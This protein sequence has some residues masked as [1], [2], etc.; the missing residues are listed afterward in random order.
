[1][2]IQ[3]YL[4]FNGNAE[5]A[6]AFYEKALGAPRSML[7]RFSETPDPVPEGMIPA[8]WGDKV[9]HASIRVGEIDLM[10]SDG[11]QTVGEGHSGFSLSLTVTESEIDRVFAALGEGGQVT[12]PLGQTFF[13]KKFGGVTDRFGVTWMLVVPPD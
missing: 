3:P 11:C 4:F 12:M 2:L 13:A 7:M 10:F 8:D 6:I 1:M 5:E 9:M